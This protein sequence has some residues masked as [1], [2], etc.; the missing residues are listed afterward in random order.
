MDHRKKT[1]RKSLLTAGIISIILVSFVFTAASFFMFSRS[2]YSR[3][4]AQLT[5]I[6]TYVEHHIDADDLNKCYETGERSEKYNELQK[7]LNSTVDDLG[8]IYLY[9]VVPEPDNGIM[10]NVIS[11]TNA[12]EIAAGEEDMPLRETTDAYT[13]KE[14]RRFRSA[15]DEDG[16]SFFKEVSDYGYYYTACKP[17]KT[18]DGVTFSLI[19]ADISI[20]HLRGLQ[21]TYFVFSALI[22]LLI[23]I[24]FAFII[25]LW[26]RKNITQPIKEL[27]KSAR[28]FAQRS[29][30]TEDFSR[31][32]F[33]APEIKSENEIHSLSATIKLMSENM[34]N[35]VR[36]ILSAEQRAKTAK[37]EADDMT[38]I[39]YRDPLTHVKSKAAFDKAAEEL[40]RKIAD[41]TAGD[42]SVLMADING[43][44]IINDTYGHDK[45]DLYI[46]G[47]C[48]MMCT[49]YKNSP[50]FRIGGDEFTV[51]LQGEDYDNRAALYESLWEQ[52]EAHAVDNSVEPWE[53][54]SVSAGMADHNGDPSVPL[55][56]VLKEADEIMYKN[57]AEFKKRHKQ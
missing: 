55:E 44:K 37:E 15:W 50:V 11:A 38:R 13:V 43:L 5:N 19:C 53:R 46:R 24:A 48:L 41:G 1:L 27:E 57:K 36:S 10:I 28:D 39:A 7:F 21:I 33:K 45:G 35:Y 8:L 9:I 4:D 29:S 3:Y 25:S 56:T 23:A 54:Y 26:M 14:L 18:S 2:M 40:N 51:I 47:A 34:K 16:I 22:M 52:V 30:E 20:D 49:I 6:V 12:E 31:L 42:T 32:E 17:L